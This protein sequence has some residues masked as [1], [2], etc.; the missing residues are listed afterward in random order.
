M[1]TPDLVNGRINTS[2]I[3][4]L[5]LINPGAAGVY[6]DIPPEMVAVEPPLWCRLIAGYIQDRGFKVRIVDAEACRMSPADVALEVARL[7]PKMAV[8]VAYGHQPSASTQTMPAAGAIARAIKSHPMIYGCSLGIVGGHVSTLW[9]QTLKDEVFDW[10]AVGEG[11][12]TI[13][14]LLREREPHEVPG[15]AR[16]LGGQ[17]IVNM[18]AKLIPID[19]LQGNVWS[20]LP[21]HRY[22]AHNWQNFGWPSGGYA[23]IHTSLGC[24]YRCNFCCIN[25]PFAQP[26]SKVN[27]YRMRDPEDVVA[28]IERLVTRY[29]VNTIKITDEMFVLNEGHYTA[30]CEALIRKQLGQRV[31]IW[32]YARIDTVKPHTLALLLSAGIRWLALGIESASGDVRDGALKALKDTDIMRAVADVRTSGIKVIANYIFGL[33]G[34]TLESMRDTLRLAVDLNTEFANF[35]TAMAYP[36]SQLYTRA[37]SEGGWDLPTSWMGYSQHAYECQPLGSGAVSAA[38]VLRF[39]DQAFDEYFSGESYRSMIAL[40]FGPAGL[41]QIDAMMRTKL[42]RKLLESSPVAA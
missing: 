9:A 38:E 25:A 37:R 27:Q 16:R 19:Q 28:E 3:P 42:R 35:Y 23:S 5:V 39:R 8:V 14:E 17:A 6:G 2:S 24:P 20:M 13:L 12:I 29:G 7:E 40:K 36:G 10:V 41:R 21:M 26:G 18:P 22:R 1:Q 32:A 31:N 4:D 34:D 11:P 15:L 30:I 33:P